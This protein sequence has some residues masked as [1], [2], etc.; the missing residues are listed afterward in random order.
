MS[1]KSER[2]VILLSKEEKARVADLAK[3][4]HV[5]M[6]D[7][8]RRAL[9]SLDRSK[10]TAQ[11]GTAR[12]LAAREEPAA[13]APGERPTEDELAALSATIEISD[14]QAQVLEQLADAAVA[15]MERANAALDRAFKELEATTEYCDRKRPKDMFEDILDE[16][17]SG[18]GAI[19]ADR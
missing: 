9:L 6:G 19:R 15:K 11:E 8:A 18:D 3:R 16:L 1:T 4:E 12:V 10:F 5:S 2:L 13:F 7:L 14:K 17:A